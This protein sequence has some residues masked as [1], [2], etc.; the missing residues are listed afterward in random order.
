MPRKAAKSIGAAVDFLLQTG[1]EQ[2]EGDAHAL[3]VWVY[4]NPELP[5]AMRLQAAQAAAPYERPRLASI[6]ARIDGR[7]TLGV[8]E[9]AGEK[10]AREIN[11]LRAAAET[12]GAGLLRLKPPTTH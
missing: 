10:L 1:K 5:A 4:K 2:F 7:V 3:L 12:E 8:V 11:R 6:D 9:D